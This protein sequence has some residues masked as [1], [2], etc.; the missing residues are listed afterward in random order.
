MKRLVKVGLLCVASLFVVSRSSAQDLIVLS[1]DAV[2]EL[3][4]KIIEVNDDNVKY[5]EWNT[6][7]GKTITIS[8]DDILYIKYQNGEKRKFY[9]PVADSG[10][11]GE[12][13]S[14]WKRSFGTAADTTRPSY[15]FTYLLPDIS[16]D[17]AFH[18]GIERLGAYNLKDNLYIQS[19]LGWFFGRYDKG[20]VA[21]IHHT[22]SIPISVG[23]NLPLGSKNVWSLDFRTGP[24]MSYVVAGRY[25]YGREEIR[26]KY[27][28]DIK[29]FHASYDAGVAIMFGCLGIVVEYNLALTP[30]SANTLKA[31]LKMMF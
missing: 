10:T 14:F 5:T 19:G 6:S 22:L 17:K 21:T 8:T 18:M 7:D 29:R 11:H 30:H 2:D 24:R 16:A 27:F 3:Q 25:K 20:G 12:A 1:N 9:T 13:G 4:V 31:G 28:D 23:Y 15:E 26:F